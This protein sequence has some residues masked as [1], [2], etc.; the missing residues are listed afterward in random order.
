ELDPFSGKLVLLNGNAGDVAARAIEAQDQTG[1]DR[2]GHQTDDRYDGRNL[3]C[4]QR[5]VGCRGGD[6]ID[7]EPDEFSRYVGSPFSASFREAI[8]EGDGAALDPAEFVQPRD[9]PGKP[10]SVGRPRTRYEHADSPYALALLRTRHE[11]PCGRAAEERHQFAPLQSI[12]QHPLPLARLT[13]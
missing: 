11:R 10:F 9:Q 3:L 6:E 7:F 8:L 12:E 1:A 2:V 5:H 13:A 4:R